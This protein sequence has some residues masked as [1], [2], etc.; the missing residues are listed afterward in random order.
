MKK[1]NIF[2]APKEFLEQI[3]QE[4]YIQKNMKHKNIVKMYGMS[5]DTEFCYLF[6]EF[7]T[8]GDL[9]EK[10]DFENGM[11]VN[12]VK[13]YLK[14]LMS[15]LKYIHGCGIVHRDIKPDNLLI[16]SSGKCF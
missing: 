16:N 8:G 3:Q 12:Q 5:M 1:I 7:V 13:G 4:Y 10:I 11:P 6:Q 2:G 15:G 14:Q 9:F